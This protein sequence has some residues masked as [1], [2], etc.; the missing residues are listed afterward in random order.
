M[1]NKYQVMP[2]LGEAEFEALKQDIQDNGLQVAIEYDGQGNVLDGHHRLKIC[3][4]LGITKWPRVIREGLS[5]AEKFAHARR[6]NMLRRHLNQEQKRELIR[7][8]LKATPEISDRRISGMLGVSQPTVST[9]RK[10]MVESGEV[11]NFITTVGADGVEQPRATERKTKSIY[12]P[13]NPEDILQSARIVRQERQDDDRERRRLLRE[14]ALKIPL[15]EGKYRTVCIDP[16]W[17]MERIQSDLD[18]NAFGFPYPTMTFNEIMNYPVES[19]AHD[20]CHVY[21]WTTQKWL[22]RAHYLLEHWGFPAIFTMVWFKN[23]GYQPMGLPQYNCEFVVF[24]RR[25][26]LEFLD[27][28]QFFTCFEAPRR[29]HS[30]KPDEF[31]DVV[32]RVSPE[33]RIDVFSREPRD[34]FAQHGLEADKFGKEAAS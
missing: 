10:E 11:I 28:K 14:E 12:L 26:A 2:D 25:G 17:P 27:T 32:R 20:Q 13:E 4:E 9:V 1:E 7:D 34:G 3:H 31:Y 33:P 24:G 19:F 23:G 16:P 5:E 18:P 22:F 29:E 6:M 8:Q 15:P 30:R 21:L